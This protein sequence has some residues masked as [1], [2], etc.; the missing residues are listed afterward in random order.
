MDPGA[1]LD[2]ELPNRIEILRS[3]EARARRVPLILFTRRARLA[4]VR[5]YVRPN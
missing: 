4:L 2:F 1:I 3:S 5:L